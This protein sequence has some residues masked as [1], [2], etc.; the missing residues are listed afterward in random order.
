MSWVLSLLKGACF[1]NHCIPFNALTTI[2]FPTFQ[3]I[4]E[5]AASKY[6]SEYREKII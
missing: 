2:V 4:Y 3:K 1:I 5:F 6:M